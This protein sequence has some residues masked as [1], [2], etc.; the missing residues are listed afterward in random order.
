VSLVPADAVEHLIAL[1]AQHSVK[2]AVVRYER[3]AL[4]EHGPVAALLRW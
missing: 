2:V 1:A 4:R 3:D